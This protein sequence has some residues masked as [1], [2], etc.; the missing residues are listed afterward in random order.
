M[1]L[2]PLGIGRRRGAGAALVPALPGSAL[3]PPTTTVRLLIRPFRL[4]TTELVTVAARVVA[5]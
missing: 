3:V 4:V 2:L 1:A 5:R